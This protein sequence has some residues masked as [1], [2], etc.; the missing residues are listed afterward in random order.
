MR[1]LLFAGALALVVGWMPLRAV[2]GSFQISPEIAGEINVT[3]DSSSGWIPTADEQRRA[4]DAVRHYLDAI[5]RRSYAEAYGLYDAGLK[6]EVTLAQF[7]QDEKEFDDKA[8]PVQF[9]RVLK[10]TWTKDPAQAPSPG[11][12]VA[13]DLAKQF[14]NVDRDCG[15]IVLYQANL[16]GNFTIVHLEDNYLDNASARE[17]EKKH[18]KTEVTKAW[19]ALSRNCPN[20][21]PQSETP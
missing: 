4:I 9:W 12:Y 17:I 21:V 20:Y 1:S 5:E 19:A 2:A 14:A 3:S 8:G 18:S 11:I 7:T 10:I 13:V 6:L 15:Y 16:G